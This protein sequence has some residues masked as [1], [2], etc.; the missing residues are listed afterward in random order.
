MRRTLLVASLLTL[1]ACGTKEVSGLTTAPPSPS[2]VGSA[3]IVSDA[4]GQLAV[5]IAARLH[6]G[7]SVHLHL[8]TGPSCPLYVRMFPDSTGEATVVG[9]FPAHCPASAFTLDLAPGDSI[10]L[11]QTM[12]ASEFSSLQPMIY[13]FNVG[14]VFDY[15][16]VTGWAGAV[17][18][19]L[20]PAAGAAPAHER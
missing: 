14:V 8:G 17:R 6:N 9:G 11:S 4:G 16:S 20:S 18:L 13:G 19:P 2:L 15:G 12:A 1:T 7:T 10:V 5:E 3:R